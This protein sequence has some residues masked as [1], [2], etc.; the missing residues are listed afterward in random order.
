MRK[1]EIKIPGKE[2]NL[3]LGN[4]IFQQI[5]NIFLKENIVGDLFLV[6]DSNVKKYYSKLINDV[7]DNYK[8]RVESI[9][10]NSSEKNKSYAT[11]QKIHAK[12]ISKNYGRDSVV[13]ALGGGII[14]DIAGFAASTYMRGIKYIQIPTTLLASVDSSVGG[15]TGIN[16]NNTKNIIGTFYQPEL[17]IVDSNFF[18]TL[19]FEERLCGLG[20][21]IKYGFLTNNKLFNF[22]KNNADKILD[23]DHK[24]IRK[25]ISESIKF[26]GSVVEADEKEMGVRKILNL[27]HTFAHAFEVQQKHKLKHGQAVIVGI[28]AA[29]YLSNYMNL[30]PTIKLNKY[31]DFL[32]SFGNHIHL[33]KVDTNEFFSVMRRDKKNRE[34]L[35]KFVLLK[36]IGELVTDV[37]S[38]RNLIKKSIVKTIEHF[39]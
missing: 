13:V 1:I 23:V 9:T 37:T 27:G 38:E 35:I 29:L 28:T 21:V 14:G 3:Y 18:T 6:I 19:P 24:I 33:S 34:N 17:V 10:I 26:K 7:F 20:E 25:I 15:K 32:T 5:E 36:D 8:F 39:S 12:L 4:R 11:L 16:F 31:L 30:L 22:V 2:Y